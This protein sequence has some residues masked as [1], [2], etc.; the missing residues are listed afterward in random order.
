LNIERDFSIG[1]NLISSLCTSAVLCAS[2]VYRFYGF[3]TAEAQ[4]TAEVHRDRF[5][6]SRSIDYSI[7]QIPF[8]AEI[9]T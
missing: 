2:A 3:F 9:R 8:L 7:L 6:L 5:E 1:P 4:R